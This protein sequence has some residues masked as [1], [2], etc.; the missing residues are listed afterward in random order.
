MGLASCISLSA[1][2]GSGGTRGGEVAG[3]NGVDERA[4]DDLGTGGLR[5]GSPEDQDELEGIVEWEPIDGADSALKDSQES[6]DHPVSKPLSVIDLACAE[7]SSKRVI[8]GNDKASDI[9]QEL[10]G[11]VEKDEEKVE[12][13]ETEDSVDLGDRRLLLEVVE[14]GVLGQLLV[15]LGDMSL[16]AVLYR[17]D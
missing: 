15:Q 10:A 11:D 13:A 3:E 7:Q 1:E 14:S 12:G 6:I 8:A 16:G 9:D 17:H 5:K 4:E 2:V